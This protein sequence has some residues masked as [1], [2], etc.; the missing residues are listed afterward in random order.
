MPQA[1]DVIGE[2]IGATGFEG[3]DQL[4]VK[5]KLHTSPENWRLVSGED[6]G[7]SWIAERNEDEKLA[8]FSHPL[9]VSYACTGIS[10]WPRLA[11]QIGFV[12]EF[13]RRD[14]AGYGSCMIP[15]SAGT[16]EREV[17]MARPIGSLADSF[18][19][20]LVGGHPRYVHPDVIMSSESRFGH[21]TESAGVVHIMV[22][23]VLRDFDLFNVQFS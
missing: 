23:V 20:A 13:G 10:G 15:M 22:T 1:V 21:R 5:W 14:L 16:H 17:V 18:S 3:Y 9:D 6:D 12:D 19:A 2:I 4:F 7:H 11:L 8:I